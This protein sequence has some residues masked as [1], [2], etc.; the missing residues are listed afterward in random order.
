LIA[1]QIELAP[2]D[3]RA[4]RVVAA[5]AGFWS[6]VGKVM[7]DAP[8]TRRPLVWLQVVPTAP[9]GSSRWWFRRA[10]A[11]PK[12]QLYSSLARAAEARCFRP[13][14]PI[15]KPHLS[16]WGQTVSA[17]ARDPGWDDLRGIDP[18]KLMAELFPNEH[19][20]Q[21]MVRVRPRLAELIE[22]S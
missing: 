16:A 3:A 9:A 15:R 20:T 22:Q 5:L 13:L 10:A 19:T 4:D 8:A 2:G 18:T 17:A 6:K 1:S 7:G 12:D 11:D 21:P 14:G